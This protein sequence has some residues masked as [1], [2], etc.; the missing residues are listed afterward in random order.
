MEV[1]SNSEQCGND[2]AAEAAAAS[3]TTSI[4]QSIE[5]TVSTRSVVEMDPSR[6]TVN[7]ET[8]QPLI[9]DESEYCGK[10][11]ILLLCHFKCAN[12]KK[13]QLL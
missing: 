3:V 9:R 7:A 8:T 10:C 6:T 1:R 13:K 12:I 2:A 4:N 11:S 5:S